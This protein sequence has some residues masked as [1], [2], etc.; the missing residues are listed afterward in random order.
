MKK[1]IYGALLCALSIAL[2]ANIVSNQTFIR[3]RDSLTNNLILSAASKARIAHV[4]KEAIG[5]TVSIAPYYR[6]SHNKTEIA[7]NFGGGQSVDHN[8]NGTLSIEAGQSPSFDAEALKLYSGAID[9]LATNNN[10]GMYGVVSF[11]PKRTECGVHISAQQNLDFLFKGLSL[12]VEMPVVHVAHS[13][14][15][16]MRGVANTNDNHNSIQHY[17]AGKPLVKGTTSAQAPLIAALIDGVKHSKTEIA[18]IQ[19]GAHYWLYS[20]EQFRLSSM[21]H[22]TIPTGS[23]STGRNLFEPMIGSGHITAGLK[24][25]FMTKIKNIHLNVSGDYRYLFKADQT[26]TVGLYNHWYNTLATGSQYHN[27]ALA[28][29][30]TALPA[31]NVTNRVVTV[32][33]GHMFDIVAGA[34]YYYHNFAGSLYYNLHAHSAE[35]VELGANSRWFD[36]EYGMLGHAVDVSDAIIVGSDAFTYGGALQQQSNTS[37]A[38]KDTAGNPVGA[39]NVGQYYITTDACTGRSDVTHKLAAIAEWQYRKLAYPITISV[40]AEYEMPGFK[41]N[42]S[43]IH[44]WAVW[45]KLSIC[46]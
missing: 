41:N 45:S 8:Q 2:D 30:N 27:I 4:K 34:R 21:A 26:R 10:S 29:T 40:G 36:G 7:Q 19:L 39:N 3:S 17:F 46:F 15:A 13:L 5:A 1:I 6:H 38:T 22:I 42:N 35:R 20:N 43:G 16:T 23:K 37:V 33:P 28:G 31:A 9:H 12:Q 11:A 14:G 25:T 32:K 44:S 24:T 18:D